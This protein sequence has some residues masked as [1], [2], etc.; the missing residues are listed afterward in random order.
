MTYSL[1][2]IIPLVALAHLAALLALKEFYHELI[3]LPPKK[4]LA[5]KT[6]KLMP[7]EVATSIALE[8][9]PKEVK[10]L[11]EIKSSPEV[12]AAPT[13]VTAKKT[14][15]AAKPKKEPKA[16]PSKSQPIV[17]NNQELSNRKKELVALAK[18]KIGKI[19]PASDK[20]LKSSLERIATPR[21]I[22]QLSF[23]DVGRDMSGEELAYRDALALR[24]KLSLKLPEYGNVKIELEVNPAGKVEHL[25]VLSFE[26]LKN[27][28]YI[29]KQLP[30]IELPTFK[31][32]DSYNFTIVMSNE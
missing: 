14:N 26:S 16:G 10:P 9:S 12:K 1:R 2:W 22:E 25:K 18:E 3:P 21:A 32:R 17:K 7:K 29:E 19:G 31:D 27:A 23:V 28:A 15:Q 20:I 4:I 13:K 24:L 6:V 30:Q 8:P 11:S 5:V